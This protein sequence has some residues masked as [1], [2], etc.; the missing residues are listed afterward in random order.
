MHIPV[1][2]Q[3][4]ITAL[5]PHSG[6]NYL[7]ATV[8]AGGHAAAI[9]EGSSPDGQLFGF[10]Q[11]QRAVELA[12]HTLSRFGQRVHLLHT[13]FDRLTEVAQ[14]QQIP[15]LDGIL[16]DLGVSSMHLDQPER[17]F[18]FQADGPLDMR[19]DLAHG[20]TAADLVNHLP[21]EELANL[22]YRYG[23]E[24]HSRRIAK[25]MIR[26]RPIRRTAEL[27]QIVARAG[28]YS[29][30]EQARIHPATRTFQALRIA[31]NDELGA[32]ERV[33]PQAIAWLKP[34]GRLAVISFHSLE[35]RI[36]KQFFQQ[37]SRDCI[38]PPEQ[39]ICT[40][41]HKATV[42]IITKRPIV[43]NLSEIDANPRARSAKLR[44]VE[45]KGI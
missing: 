5:R 28:G 24:R 4:V 8:G 15:R 25:A 21:E 19:M 32:L 2:L 38:C 20:Q 6:G 45:L 33:L 16:L 34:G 35:D 39:P 29:R 30:Q 9:L 10:D 40:C 27:A 13:N 42:N 31:V 23:E 7:D 17:G 43:P 11:D 41:R 36:V 14:A 37:E 18:S 44:V 12:A 3:E 26:A 1:L 22:I